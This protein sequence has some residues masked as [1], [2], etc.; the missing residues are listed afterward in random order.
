MKIFRDIPDNK[1]LFINPV[2]TVG[3]FD[4]VH[5]GHLRI[6]NTLVERAESTGGEPVVVT[7]RE[8]PR[9]ILNPEFSAEILTTAE[10][11]I[12]LIYEAGVRNIIVL[13]FTRETASMSARDFYNNILI[14][15]IDIKELVIGYDHAF[16]K[17]REGNFD[18]LSKIASETG[19]GLTRV[20]EEQINGQ[21]VSSTRIRDMLNAGAVEDAAP[22]L[23]RPYSLTGRVIRGASR[24][25]IL[26]FPTANI[27]PDSEEKIVPCGGVY[28]VCARAGAD[29]L[30]G[31]M[32]IGSN[33]T[34]ETG[35]LNIEV[36]FLDFE[37]DIYDEK[38]SISF[39]RRLRDEKKFSGPDEL[40]RQIRIDRE[41]AVALFGVN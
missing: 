28:A 10:E 11:K 27:K 1:N 2:L 24:G 18:Y 15:K 6:I 32:N 30:K 26:G 40:T 20:M 36:H 19:I 22:L 3:N 33:P 5:L 16:G 4:G 39:M 8:H 25:R 23:G 37:G 29:N 35:G 12:N 41:K 14:K 13:D 34:F 38:I 9:K 31:I 7:F 17:N 21:P